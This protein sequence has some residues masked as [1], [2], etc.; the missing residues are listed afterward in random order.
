VQN[1]FTKPFFIVVCGLLV[2]C[3]DVQ[4]SLPLMTLRSTLCLVGLSQTTKRNNLQ[5][6]EFAGLGEIY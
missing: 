4:L 5:H 2:T 6:Y 1:R 3:R